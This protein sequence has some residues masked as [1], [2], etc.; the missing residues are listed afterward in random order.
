[1]FGAITIAAFLVLLFVFDTERIVIPFFVL[2]FL[3]LTVRFT[4]ES[5]P[6]LRGYKIA[7]NCEANDDDFQRADYDKN[8][9]E[10][11]E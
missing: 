9:N 3:I 7:V 2:S 5:I 8:L 1:M 6:R 11:I 4:V 10:W